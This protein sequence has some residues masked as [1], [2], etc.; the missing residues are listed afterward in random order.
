MSPER[1]V[2]P[3]LH[4]LRVDQVDESGQVIARVETPFSR[5][6]M[7]GSLDNEGFVIVQPGNNLWRIARR[8]YGRGWQY[9]VIYEAN[10]D[11]IRDPDLIY[12]G[13]VF[14]LPETE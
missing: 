5:S 8:T 7:V 1:D 14:V 9:T 11:Q 2:P 13:Q 6:A 4:I 3:G 12:P 10:Q